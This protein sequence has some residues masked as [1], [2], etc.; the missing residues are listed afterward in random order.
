MKVSE[1]IEKLK[2][3]PQDKEVTSI[4]DIVKECNLEFYKGVL[5]GVGIMM[6]MQSNVNRQQGSPADKNRYS[7]ISGD[8]EKYMSLNADI[9]NV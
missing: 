3:I 1:L 6:L 8:Y 2:D 5:L 4:D 7:N 9:K